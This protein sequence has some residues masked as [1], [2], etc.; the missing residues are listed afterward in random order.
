MLPRLCNVNGVSD[1]NARA[2]GKVLLAEFLDLLDLAGELS[3]EGLLQRL[4]LKVLATWFTIRKYGDGG[5]AHLGLARRVAACAI[6]GSGSP[7]CGGRSGE[8]RAEGARGQ[9]QGGGHG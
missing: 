6:E 7:W 1:G 4:Q 5:R 9:S 3:G 2:N 8:S